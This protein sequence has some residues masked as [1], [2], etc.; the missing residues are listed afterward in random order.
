MYLNI[1]KAMY[2]RPTAIIIFSGEEQIFFS[3]IRNK[4]IHPPQ[5]YSA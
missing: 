3:K 2:N 1:I 5:F 4:D